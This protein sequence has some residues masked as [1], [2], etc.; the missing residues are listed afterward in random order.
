MDK[1]L[2]SFEPFKQTTDWV[3]VLTIGIV[4]LMLLVGLWVK[5]KSTLDTNR[6]SMLMMIFFFIGTIAAG[7]TFFR[8]FSMWKLKPVSIYNNRIET[9]YGAAPF[10]NIRDFY[11]KLERHYKPMNPNEIQ[12][13][14][15]YF[16]L[17]ERNDKTHV[18]S[19]GDYPVDS[20]LVKLNE[21]MGY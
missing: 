2:Y 6:R 4:L 14:A 16:F 11:I 13:S 7:T 12:D 15:R 1:P 19:E 3:L 18:L 21:A 20:I 10:N 5:K 17:L 9:P 8:L